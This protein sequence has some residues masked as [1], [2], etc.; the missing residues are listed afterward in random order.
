MSKTRLLTAASGLVALVIALGATASLS[1]QSSE[2]SVE[3]RV[4][5]R[6]SEAGRVEFSLRDA[7][8]EFWPPSARYLSPLQRGASVGE[9]L[10]SSAVEIGAVTARVNAMPREDGS[11]EFAVEVAGERHEPARN[12]L[13]ADNVDAGA[14]RWLVSTSVTIT[15]RVNDRAMEQ[16][17]ASGG[18]RFTVDQC[19]DIYNQQALRKNNEGVLYTPLSEFSREYLLY[20][21]NAFQT[22]VDQKPTLHLARRAVDRYDLYLRQCRDVTIDLRADA[23]ALSLLRQQI[24]EVSR[25]PVNAISG[26][27]ARCFNLQ[28]G[29]II[30]INVEDITSERFGGP[31]KTYLRRGTNDDILYYPLLSLDF[32]RD[33]REV[34]NSRDQ[35]IQTARYVVGKAEPF[36]ELCDGTLELS[37]DG[38]PTKPD[39]RSPSGQKSLRS[40]LFYVNAISG[41]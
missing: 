32:A 34:D 8:G 40:Y 21:V 16:I 12:I 13:T 27:E 3:L 20:L 15:I 9:W 25:N 11:V 33:L 37:F 36:I 41:Y 2:V 1:A 7:A 19:R 26:A 10:R 18:T 5:A 28:H 14:N 23:Y 24:T 6:V 30:R 38:Q 4:A 35:W 39:P 31:H 29:E 17:E 22:E